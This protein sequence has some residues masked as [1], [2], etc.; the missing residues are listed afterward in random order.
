MNNKV[1]IYRN[2]LWS[3]LGGGAPILVAIFT[4]PPLIAGLGD[5]RFGVLAIGW[6]VMGYFVLSDMGIGLATKKYI[7]SLGRDTRPDS[8]RALIWTSL[9][10]LFFWV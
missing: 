10:M 1:F 9:S 6:L 2:I 4:I 5:E 8:S 3:L 7:S